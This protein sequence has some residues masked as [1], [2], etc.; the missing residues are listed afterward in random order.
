MIPSFALRARFGARNDDIFIVVKKTRQ[1]QIGT[2]LTLI[3]VVTLWAQAR[4]EKYVADQ[5]HL[6]EPGENRTISSTWAFFRGVILRT[7]GRRRS[8]PLEQC[9]PPN[10]AS[11]ATKFSQRWPMRRPVVWTTK[12]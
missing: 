7:D 8:S 2:W 6:K 10:G 12:Q 3:I 11:K 4:A 9:Q 5:W 1:Q